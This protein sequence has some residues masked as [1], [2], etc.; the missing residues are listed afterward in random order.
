MARRISPKKPAVQMRSVLVELPEDQ[1][2]ALS[3]KAR[4]SGW[5]AHYLA[6]RV[7][8]DWLAGQ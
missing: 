4:E 2:L 7:L 5:S 3:V 1:M 6:A 8:S